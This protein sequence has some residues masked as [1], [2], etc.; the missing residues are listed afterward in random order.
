[1]LEYLYAC[2]LTF[3]N[4]NQALDLTNCSNVKHIDTYGSNFSVIT[5]ANN[6]PLEYLRLNHPTIL[7]FTNLRKLNTF[8]SSYDSIQSLNIDNIDESN[9]NSKDIVNS[10][11]DQS[12]IFNSYALNNIQWNINNNS[13]I[14]N[15]GI[16]ILDKL[17]ELYKDSEDKLPNSLTGKIIVNAD[18]YNE[19]KAID[20]YHKYSHKDVYPKV[21]IQ[22]L[23]D[24]AKLYN[25]EVINGQGTVIWNRKIV[26]NT[27]I[28]NTFFEGEENNYIPSFGKLDVDQITKDST[29]DTIYTKKGTWNIYNAD[30]GDLLASQVESDKNGYPIYTHAINSNIRIEHYFEESV[31]YYTVILYDGDNKTKLLELTGSSGGVTYKTPL[32][33]IL[34]EMDTIPYKDDSKLGLKETYSYSGYHYIQNTNNALPNSY[35]IVSD[36]ELYPVFDLIPDITKLTPKYE[37]FTFQQNNTTNYTENLTEENL[38]DQELRYVGYGVSPKIRLRGKVVLPLLTKD[39]EIITSYYGFGEQ[40]DI[41]HIFFEDRKIEHLFCLKYLNNKG[42]FQNCTNLVYFDF[43]DNLGNIGQYGFAGSSLN[44]DLYDNVIYLGKNLRIIDQLA[45]NNA[46]QSSKSSIICISPET[47]S[48]NSQ[49]ISAN[50]RLMKD[51]IIY[52]GGPQEPSKLILVDPEPTHN[53]QWFGCIQSNSKSYFGKI[54]FYTNNYTKEN[55]IALI[56]KVFTSSASIGIMEERIFVISV[57]T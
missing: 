41:T 35:Q 32:I 26:P 5:I 7:N 12:N 14:N 45:F 22:F 15:N 50:D 16:V 8:D 56:R 25:V 20:L 10:S 49:C 43:H 47:L 21:D 42:C 24:E 40:K 4:T 6:A 11:F 33:N 13:E 31:R 27:S 55:D 54:N 51:S 34:N 9:I 38:S 37:Y 36:C 46:F 39:N 29:T 30:T 1:M 28:S 48:L 57:S 17:I 18:A 52:I 3:N 2:N 19:N 23:G 53:I 44:I